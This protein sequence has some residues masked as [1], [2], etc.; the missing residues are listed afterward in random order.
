MIITR[1]CYGWFY[2]VQRILILITCIKMLWWWTAETVIYRIF[3]HVN[4][5]G[6]GRLQLRELKR[7]NLIAALQQVDEEEDINKVLR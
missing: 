3:Y 2:L 5:A 6:N 7:S 4:K 1:C